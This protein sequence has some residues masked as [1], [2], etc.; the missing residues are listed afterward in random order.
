MGTPPGRLQLISSQTLGAHVPRRL[1]ALLDTIAR[2]DH[3]SRD[4]VVRRAGVSEVEQHKRRSR[5]DRQRRPTT[6]A[7]FDA[8]LEAQLAAIVAN[9][10]PGRRANSSAVRRSGR[11][12]MRPSSTLAPAA[13]SACTAAGF[14]LLKAA[15]CRGARPSSS[16]AATSAPTSRQAATSSTVAVSKNSRLFEVSHRAGVG[17]FDVSV[18]GGDA[19][20]EPWATACTRPGSVSACRGV[21]VAASAG[22]DGDS[23]TAAGGR[24]LEPD[25]GGPP[26][27]RS[28]SACSPSRYPVASTPRASCHERIA[29]RVR[30]PEQPV[31]L[32]RVEAFV[33]QPLLNQPARG[34]I[35]AQR[36]LDSRRILRSR[37]HRRPD[38]WC[39]RRHQDRSCREDERQQQNHGEPRMA[40]RGPLSRKSPLHPLKSKPPSPIR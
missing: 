22:A 6:C 14:S 21:S 27:A 13:R 38:P 26:A 35:E 40:H 25:S 9:V 33:P 30:R 16:R 11:T 5:R 8:E 39:T 32:A 10:K 3:I 19:S 18:T 24:S 28:S 37:G 12:P 7:T 4:Q 31:R 15:Q 34:P 29:P 23:T 17:A 20:V 1:V 2:A 36:R